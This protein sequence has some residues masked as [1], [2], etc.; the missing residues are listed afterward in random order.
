MYSKDD[1]GRDL[2]EEVRDRTIRL[3]DKK[4]SG[5]MKAEEDQALYEQYRSLDENAKIFV[6]I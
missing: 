5:A 2:I 1:F 4:L 6:R 3:Y